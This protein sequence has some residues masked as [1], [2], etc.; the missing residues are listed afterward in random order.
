MATSND[1]RFIRAWYEV[2]QGD[3]RWRPIAKGRGNTSYYANIPEV[4]RWELDREPARELKAYIESKPG[5][6]H[7][8]RRI[9]GVPYYLKPGLTWSVRASRFN[10]RVMPR[11]C[12]F[13]HRG[14][15][16]FPLP[17][18]NQLAILGLLNSRI[19]DFLY[20]VNLGRF[21]HPEFLAGV[22]PEVPMVPLGEADVDRLA[23]H[24][25]E[26]WRLYR[27]LDLPN[28]TSRSFL[29]PAL[30]LHRSDDFQ[31]ACGLWHRH[32]AETTARIGVLQVEIDR[33]CFDVYDVNEPDRM[34]IEQG[35]AVH[36]DE[37]GSDGEAEDGEGLGDSSADLQSRLAADLISWSVGVGFGRFDV[38]SALGTCDEVVESD[39]FDPLPPSSPGML[40]VGD[41][42][43]LGEAPAGYP[44]ESSALFVHDPGHPLHLATNVRGVFELVFGE[45]ADQWWSETGDAVGV[46]NGDLEEWLRTKLFEH[47]LS[48]HSKPRRKAPILW[49]LGTRSGSYLVWLYAHSVSA[50]SLFRVLTEVVEPKA[51]VESQQ[52]VVLRQEAGPEPTASQRKAIDAQERFVDELRELAQGIEEL[53]PLWAPDLND[54][55]VVVLAPLWPLFAHHRV[56]SKELKRH[57]DKLSAG[58]YDWAQLAMHLW[59]ERVVPKCATDRSLAIAHGLEDVFWV[60]DD[61]GADKWHPRVHPTTPIDQLIAERTNPT[62]TAALQRQT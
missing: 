39:P 18:D 35:I 38:R 42:V 20:K 15:S 61:T 27:S 8:S 33:I 30:L 31:S 56:W 62:T 34:T 1:D 10:P 47:H 28:E 43:P 44:I 4:I 49:P 23:T 14:Y 48:T 51:R 55:V 46:A 19:V 17:S 53:A 37:D 60:H 45:T 24:A 40:T 41:G 13:S 22:L 50:D 2:P 3:L 52:L 26:C 7:W 11:E 29:L 58:D 25:H 57:W 59:P 12:V 16:T 36:E 32:V 54:G 21:A 6:T 5:N 9:A